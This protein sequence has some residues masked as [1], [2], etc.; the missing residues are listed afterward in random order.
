MGATITLEAK[1]GTAITYSV[2][3]VGAA[4]GSAYAL[5]YTLERLE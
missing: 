4:D 2:D 3:Q 1:A 5:Y